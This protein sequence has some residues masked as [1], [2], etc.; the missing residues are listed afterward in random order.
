VIYLDGDKMAGTLPLE[1]ASFEMVLS[2]A[3][4]GNP[5]AIALLASSVEEK[6]IRRVRDVEYWGLPYNTIITPGMRPLGKPRVPH[7]DVPDNGWKDMG[8]WYSLQPSDGWVEDDHIWMYPPDPRPDDD[9]YIY[10][11]S[12]HWALMADGVPKAG[13]ADTFDKAKEESI[14]AFNAI[15]AETAAS[16]PQ[17]PTKKPVPP[18]PSGWDKINEL[19]GEELYAAVDAKQAENRAWE[20]DIK[21][22]LSL[23]VYDPS[24]AKA[25]GFLDNADND[26]KP[27]PS[28][29]YHV[30]TA[31]SAVMK[32]GLK[33]RDEIG[34]VARGLGGGESDT[35]SFTDDLAT[36]GAIVEGIAGMR[37]FLNRERSFLSLMDEARGEINTSAHGPVPKR[38][39]DA[40]FVQSLKSAIGQAGIDRLING[41]DTL[42]DRYHAYS[43][44]SVWREQAGGPIDPLFF[45]TDA[46]ALM[47]TDPDEIGVI[48]VRA[49]PGAMGYQMGALGEWRTGTGRAVEVVGH[50]PEAVSAPLPDEME[51]SIENHRQELDYLLHTYD[52]VNREPG[53]G[54]RRSLTPGGSRW[55]HGGVYLSE[56]LLSSDRQHDVD[57]FEGPFSVYV[58]DD[59]ENGAGTIW[60]GGGTDTEWNALADEIARRA[61]YE[62]NYN[63][64]HLGHHDERGPGQY[65]IRPWDDRQA[66][67]AEV[68]T[69][70]EARG[71]DGIQ[72]GG[73][74]VVWNYDKLK[75]STDS[76]VRT[77][78]GLPK[79][80]GGTVS[81]AAEPSTDTVGEILDLLEPVSGDYT[82]IDTPFVDPD[83]W[84]PPVSVEAVDRG[85]RIRPDLHIPMTRDEVAVDDNDPAHDRFRIPAFEDFLPWGPDPEDMP[86]VNAGYPPPVIDTDIDPDMIDA[87]AAEGDDVS[88]MHNP[89][90]MAYERYGMGI[91]PDQMKTFV[92]FELA[93]HMS[94]A[95]DADPELAAWVDG[96][97]FSA[98][99]QKAK[100]MFTRSVAE[101]ADSSL[102]SSNAGGKVGEIHIQKIEGLGLPEADV[103]VIK[104][105]CYQWLM[106]IIESDADF[107]TNRQFAS[108]MWGAIS[109]EG[110]EVMERRILEK[111]ALHFKVD[112]PELLA[113]RMSRY[114]NRDLIL[115]NLVDRHVKTWAGTSMDTDYTSI[116]VQR[117]VEVVFGLTGHASVMDRV[118]SEE[119]D[120]AQKQYERNKPFLDAFV[121]A[122]YQNTQD[123]LASN[124]VET[125][126]AMRGVKFNTAS[127]HFMAW[128][129]E[130]PEHDVIEVRVQEEI[131]RQK[132]E[133][134]NA[135]VEYAK[136]TEGE[137][138]LRFDTTEIEKIRKE[139]E[140]LFDDAHKPDSPATQI[141]R[142]NLLVD[143]LMQQGR[144]QQQPISSWSVDINTADDFTDG[145]GLRL[146]AYIPASRIWSTSF[147][148]LG[149]LSEKELL[150]LGGTDEVDITDIR[151]PHR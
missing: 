132:R 95:C 21:V 63:V 147:T 1:D 14:A 131:A 4:A 79:W 19:E 126:Y 36:A 82:P 41:D 12:W 130:Q 104:E 42:Q 146:G 110:R 144:V 140:W 103:A 139:A 75:P 48:E 113:Q 62:D 148:G 15:K 141:I 60:D 115:L 50:K 97:E 106:D 3:L 86:A 22:G 38:P 127:D 117:A 28:T 122:V 69:T 136:N 30:T 105:K 45:G 2:E 87:L 88:P 49:K 123:F 149:C 107:A 80:R 16:R 145:S 101:M 44:F 124:N 102:F 32:D 6:S 116:S 151:R 52:A 137:D 112:D 76:D 98:T 114:S 72:V 5:E 59:D 53:T 91:Y 58:V 46:E 78:F 9:E 25:A 68:R 35:I 13:T 128:Y 26:W 39:F 119:R 57:V 34:G 138:G 129:V 85:A 31:K 17:T 83:K 121:R 20:H 27:L 61:G 111:Q 89:L 84:E 143:E 133:S 8:G 108:E 40:D 23:G 99:T 64:M 73:E 74:I 56:G 77:A 92:Q 10:M 70:L 66:F 37:Q 109:Q 142:R 51:Q 134:V 54:K 71:F 90:N 118:K 55:G 120:A 67:F 18:K 7:V 24:D 125:I 65:L 43:L 29:L 96:Y 47:K 93:R 11:H 81:A 150:V 94:A 100:Q 135:Q 33:T